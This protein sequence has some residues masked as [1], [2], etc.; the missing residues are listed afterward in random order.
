M[1]LVE[2]LSFTWPE[3][4]LAIGAMALLIFGV[5][6]GDKAAGKISLASVV[7]LAI[8]AVL[9]VAAPGGQQ[10]VSLFNNAFRI[11]GFASFCKLLI[12]GAA[13]IAIL[14]SDRYLA[15]EKLGPAAFICG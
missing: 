12:F 2:T 15:G 13:A 14:M 10:D 11:D 9:V 3:L 1:S 8:A 7:L 5:F 6:A 4:V